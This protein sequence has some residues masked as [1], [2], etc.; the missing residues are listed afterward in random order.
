MSVS[1]SPVKHKTIT[2]KIMKLIQLGYSKDN[3]SS[4]VLAGKVFSRIANPQEIVFL[5][6]AKNSTDCFLASLYFRPVRNKACQTCT[7]LLISAHEARQGSTPGHSDRQ[8]SNGRITKTKQ[9]DWGSPRGTCSTGNC[10]VSGK[11]RV[12]MKKTTGEKFHELK[13]AAEM[14]GMLPARLL[15][16]V[17][18]GAVQPSLELSTL[19]STKYGF[20]DSDVIALSKLADSEQGREGKTTKADPFVDNGTQEN[21]TV[22][23]VASM[24]RLSPDTIQ[25]LFEEEPGVV[26]LGNKNPRGKRKRIT[27]RIPRG[28][29][30]RVKKRR[31]NT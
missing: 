8:E 20:T 6:V 18:Q 13:E 26:V 30:D 28:V 24:W 27:L 29:M 21:F 9:R 7:Y 23:E 25:R 3:T 5:R 16:L 14:S 22:A 1:S 31:S 17:R 2:A 12:S 10:R 11:Q 15:E 19:G 4:I